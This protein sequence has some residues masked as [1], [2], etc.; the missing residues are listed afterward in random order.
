MN[1]DTVIIGGGLAGLVC[2]IKL[3]EKG[4]RC[5]IINN[6]QAA[7]DF[8]SGSL[9][10]LSRLPDGKNVQNIDRT[11]AQL[12]EQAPQHPYSV[13]GQEV[14]LAKAREFEQLAQSL[15]LDLLGTLAQN[16]YRVTPLGG[17]RAS[18][19]SPNSVPTVLEGEAFA[20]DRIAILGIE[21]YHDFQPQMLADNL[22]Q[23][24]PFAHCEVSTGYLNIP[25]LDQLRQA[26][27]EFRSVN[28]AQLLE[29]KLSFH[30]LVNEIKEAA[31]GA[32]AVFLPACFGLDTQVFFT[33]LREATGLALFELPTLPPSLL[34]IRQHKQLRYRFEKSGGLMMNGDRALRAELDGNRVVKIYT[35][36][37]QDIAISAQHFVLASGSF[38]SNGLVAEFDR[39]YEPV[40]GADILEMADF[41]ADKRLSWT[42]AR[43]SQPQPYQSA[44]VII[45]SHCQ[46][47]KSGQFLQNLFAAGNVIGGY[48]GIELGCGSGVAVVTALW[49]AEQIGGGDE[50]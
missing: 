12:V 35:E 50:Y 6:G 9:D 32:S 36:I 39:I 40:F 13:L 18:W 34:G 28:I 42:H 7:I 41:A 19:L 17:L 15:N 44:G 8:S 49:A 20:H 5:A 37:H 3:Q 48:N 4:Q 27:R 38:F 2:G 1:F 46:V 26:A 31:K 22:L 29:H 21:G 16:H 25:E 23:Q 24:A 47:Q 43:F 10:L 45:N 33:Q 30:N 14:V 11:F